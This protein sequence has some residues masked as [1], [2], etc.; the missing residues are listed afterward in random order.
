MVALE[1]LSS[2]ERNGH[3]V[4]AVLRGTGVSSDGRDASLVSPNV[5]GQ[6]L[7]LERAYRS[8]GVDPTTIEL[9]EGHGTATPTGDR[10]E[11]ETIR[12]VFGK[13]DRDVPPGVLGSVKSMIGHAMPAAGAAGLIKAVLAVHHGVYPPT[14]HGDDP[15]PALADTRFR[16][17]AEAEEWVPRGGGL[18]RAGVN[19][20]GFGGINGHVIVEEYPQARPHPGPARASTTTSATPVTDPITDSGDGSGRSEAKSVTRVGGAAPGEGFTFEALF[21]A[22]RDAADLAAQ[23]AAHVAAGAPTTDPVPPAHAGPARLAIVDPTPKRLTLAARALEKGKAWRGLNDVWV[24]PEGLVTAGGRVAFLFP[25]VEPDV[26][27][28]FTPVARWFGRELRPLPEGWSDVEALGHQILVAGRLLGEVLGDLGIAPDDIAGHSVGE[29][30]GWY[31]AELIP[32]DGAEGW[33]DG[34]RPGSF[35]VPDVVYLALGCGV[36][37]AA[38]VIADLDGM[39]VSHDNCVHQS[40]VC[41]PTAQVAV[42]KG[43]FAERKVVAQEMPFRSGFHSPA[44]APYVD[45]LR[46]LWDRMPLQPATTPLWSATSC[47][48]YPDDPEAVR[49]LAIEHLVEPVRFRELTERLYADGVRVF[50]Q[51]GVGSLASFVDDTLGKR[52]HLA[53]PCYSAKRPALDQLARVA[54]ALWVEGVDVDV[55]ALTTGAVAA[56]AAPAAE[57]GALP[58]PAGPARG[59]HRVRLQLGTPLVRLPESVRLDVPARGGERLAA[60]TPAAPA[61]MPA[62]LAS[63]HDALLS[64][65]LAASTEVVPGLRRRPDGRAEPQRRAGEPRRE[66]PAAAA[67][68]AAAR[69]AVTD[70]H[71]DIETFPWLRDHCII[72]QS[73][74]WHDLSDG[75]PVVPATG[76]IHMMG[77]AAA[78]LVPGTVVTSIADIRAA[79]FVTAEPPTDVRIRAVE[80]ADEPGLVKVTIEDPDAPNRPFARSTV[81][82]ATTPPPAP[83]PRAVPLTNTFA[84][85][86]VAQELY[87]E[88]WMFHGPSFHGVREVIELGDEG[89]DGVIEALPTP[90]ATLDCAAQVYGWW[91][92]VTEEVNSYCLPQAIDRIELYAPLPPGER[93][94]NRVRITDLQPRTVTADLELTDASGTVVARILGST[95]RRFNS[96]G[97]LWGVSRFPA[98]NPMSTRLPNGVAVVDERWRDSA[99]RELMSY[100][101]LNAAERAAYRGLVPLAQRHWLLGRIAAKD[102]VRH[103][104]WDAGA[105]AVY[106]AE[107]TIAE[108]ADG[109][110]YVAA[111]PHGGTDLALTVA[112]ATWVGAALAVPRGDAGPGVAMVTVEP[113]T[114]ARGRRGPERRRARPAPGGRRPLA[115]A[116]ARRHAGCGGRRRRRP[117]HA[118]PGRRRPDRGRPRPRRPPAGGR[119][120]GH[121]HR[122]VR[123]GP[124]P[125]RRADR[126]LRH[127]PC[128][129]RSVPRPEG[130]RPCPDPLTRRTPPA[131]PR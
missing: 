37:V 36:D 2:A 25:G 22:G 35:E 27:A 103:A 90:G 16:L 120:V 41:G 73:R 60:A 1:R 108:A 101:Y 55:A 31:P 72:Q 4:Y 69:E 106:P 62:A 75:F 98:T 7:A 105:P 114:A 89:V 51:P 8:A 33:L 50:V 76:L 128:A 42:A 53:V 122:P 96:D 131:P 17:L 78:A 14:L 26:G 110:P 116:G 84:S 29:W 109:R 82:V 130:V 124:G 97:H 127:E 88:G 5:D 40:V 93:F 92:L 121:G 104:L 45:R 113:A 100:V 129:P 66:A 59:G 30:T 11:L 123:P 18:R 24:A 54:A 85:P 43:R 81:R 87:D 112:T 83:A 9:V 15:H 71:V 118:P 12:R 10:A 67:P 70:V 6:V 32:T 48:R 95:V 63:A 44:F 49:E 91:V 20:F 79:R 21:L 117:G 80:D 47:E 28:D 57:R 111:C 94:T 65:A 3:R 119:R 77:E 19:A 99:S 102:A 68:E 126:H 38:E 52:P 115:G 107:I 39:A 86:R 58:A 74:E 64:E 61:G 13:A 23:L 34:L 46:P 56:A 125:A